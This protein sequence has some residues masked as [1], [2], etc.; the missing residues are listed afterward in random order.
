MGTR[1]GRTLYCHTRGRPEVVRRLE[2]DCIGS[3]G[4][5]PCISGM[6]KHYWGRD[7]LVIR[8]GAYAYYMG[9]DT[10]QAMPY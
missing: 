2:R 4:P 1:R 5:Y 8:A 3:A 7:A 10:G 6:R 9:K